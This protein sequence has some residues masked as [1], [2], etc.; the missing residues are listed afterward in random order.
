MCNCILRTCAVC[1]LLAGSA[2]CW[3]WDLVVLIPV[4]RLV[5]MAA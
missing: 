1:L 3:D 5:V 4:A 2:T